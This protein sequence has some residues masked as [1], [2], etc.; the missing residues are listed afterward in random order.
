[1][2]WQFW[3]RSAAEPEQAAPSQPAPRADWTRLP[4]IQRTLGPP[5]ETGGGRGFVRDLAGSH[6]PEL[7]LQPLGHEV[8]ADAP[9]GLINASPVAVPYAWGAELVTAAR[10]R[11]TGW[12]QRWGAEPVPSE[13]TSQEHVPP[14]VEAFGGASETEPEEV[15]APAAHDLPLASTPRPLQAIRSEPPAN[16]PLLTVARLELPAVAQPGRPAPVAAEVATQPAP[17]AAEATAAEAQ[18]PDPPAA[19]RLT[20]GQV[21]R[22]GLGA[23]ISSSSTVQRAIRAEATPDQRTQRDLSVTAAQEPDE[24]EPPS[25]SLSPSLAEETPAELPDAPPSARP[26]LPLQTL[27][28]SQEPQPLHEGARGGLESAHGALAD[29]RALPPAAGPPALR[30]VQRTVPEQPTEPVGTAASRSIASQ[31]VASMATSYMPSDDAPG[32]RQQPPPAAH[33]AARPA[34]AAATRPVVGLGSPLTVS[35]RA[36]GSTPPAPPAGVADVVPGAP[37]PPK[38]P[39]AFSYRPEV[40]LPAPA[41]SLQAAA[42]ALASVTG[43]ADPMPWQQAGVQPT[44]LVRADPSAPSP[45]PAGT[46]LV[47]PWA[48]RAGAPAV[49]SPSATVQAVQRVAGAEPTGEPLPAPA[50]APVMAAPIQR[51]SESVEP[52]A[53]AQAAAPAAGP[54]GGEGGGQSDKQLDDLARQLYGRIRVHLRSDLLIDR[55]RAGTLI[56][57]R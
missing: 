17:V 4:P 24:P 35:R 56:D 21:R 7:A 37:A 18:R 53:P 46:D 30:T 29:S 1:M 48:G 57:L 22:L 16:V 51:Q 32:S 10:K 39:T 25:V 5:P 49:A 54:G 12:L 14:V 50:P 34:G 47:L 42:P 55:E 40:D 43:A 41:F 31:P 44:S 9:S 33:V 52:P 8:S 45:R 11:R 26:P 6:P 28:H 23:P 27:R 20:L 38:G 15:E 13:E 3:R 36:A 19:S 2:R